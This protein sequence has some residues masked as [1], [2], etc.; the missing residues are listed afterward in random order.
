MRDP[1]ESREIPPKGM[2]LVQAL[3]DGGFSSKVPLS[4][5]KPKLSR[6]FNK[7]NTCIKCD[8]K[9]CQFLSERT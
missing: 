7:N 5:Q 4:R 6:N 2:P 8:E 3:A 9:A 1:G